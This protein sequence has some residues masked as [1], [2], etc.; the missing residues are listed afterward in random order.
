MKN[1]LFTFLGLIYIAYPV[2]AR[3]YINQK[4]D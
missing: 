2:S 1:I 3:D 4:Y